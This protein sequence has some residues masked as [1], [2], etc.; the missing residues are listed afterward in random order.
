M[1]VVPVVIYEGRVVR[2]VIF[3]AGSGTLFLV[4]V[5][6]F[7]VSKEVV[8]VMKYTPRLVP[9]LILYDLLVPALKY[10][11]AVLVVILRQGVVL[12]LIFA[13]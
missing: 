7:A 3:K 11:Q 2:V 1:V 6:K 5:L 8:P 12:V 4:L 9:V 10:W 13:G